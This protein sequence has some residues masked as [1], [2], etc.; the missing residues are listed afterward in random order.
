[1]V[2]SLQVLEFDFGFAAGQED[3]LPSQVATFEHSVSS[4]QTKFDSLPN[5]WQSSV[6]QGPSLK[7]RN[8]GTFQNRIEFLKLF[9]CKHL[10][11]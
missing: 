10:W 6:Q 8:N 5:R 9:F 7:L 2:P 3:W 4:E 1:M 11:K